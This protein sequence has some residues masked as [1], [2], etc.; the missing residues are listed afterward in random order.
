M[1]SICGQVSTKG[2]LPERLRADLQSMCGALQHRGPDSEVV[3]ITTHAALARTGYHLSRARPQVGQPLANENGPVRVV[4]DGEIYNADALRRDLQG[5]GHSFDTDGHAEVIAH[6]YQDIGHQCVTRLRG[7]FALAVWDEKN[8][9]LLLARDRLGQRPLV[10]AQV[11]D[12]VIFASAPQA[13]ASARQVNGAIDVEALDDYLRFG[14]IPWPRTIFAGVKKLPPAHILVAENGQTRVQRYWEARFDKI[15]DIAEEEAAEELL[16]LLRRAVKRMLADVDLAGVMTSGGVD[17]SLVVA[18]ASQ[19]G[20]RPLHTFSAAFGEPGFDESQ[21][22][23]RIAERYGT[24]HHAYVV[25]PDAAEDFPRLARYYGEPY[26]DSSAIATFQGCRIASREAP[27][28][29]VGEGGDDVFA[30]LR[31]HAYCLGQRPVDARCPRAQSLP[32]AVGRLPRV[33]IGPLAGIASAALSPFVSRNQALYRLRDSIEY[34]PKTLV[35]RHWRHSRL[36][37]RD[38]ERCSLLS[39]ELRAQLADRDPWPEYAGKSCIGDPEV[40][41]LNRLIS[42]DLVTYV[43]DDLCVKWDVAGAA[44]DLVVRAPFLDEDV[45]EFASRLPVDL[46]VNKGDLKYLLKR[47]IAPR[48]ISA[49]N[50][51]RRKQGFAVP[52]G[53]WWRGPLR[54]LCCDLLLSSQAVARGLLDGTTV[55]R[56]VRD[57]I[58][59]A[60]NYHERIWQ[61]LMLE[62]W[63]RECANGHNSRSGN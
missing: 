3:H 53:A 49:G 19:T 8:R 41:P 56:I 37:R 11:P 17:S 50:I 43:P 10:Y 46:K 2:V 44:N 39:A 4:C 13:A 33:I 61:L 22:A 32:L 54:D 6:L 40:A 38:E 27:V 29:L 25:C 42:A 52:V 62:L 31:R 18:L 36:I 57:H 55:A 7:A 58:D 63:L 34:V 20:C 35:E 1:S 15:A 9:K 30:G 26:A 51:D 48:F 59:G 45:V 47:V 12:G 60:R 14:Y 16:A 21:H 23:R 24:A 5:R 28:L